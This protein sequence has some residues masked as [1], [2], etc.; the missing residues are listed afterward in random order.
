[1]NNS[2][3]VSNLIS[4]LKHSNLLLSYQV[5]SILAES[6]AGVEFYHAAFMDSYCS[7]VG[8]T[9]VSCLGHWEKGMRLPI[10]EMLVGSL[11]KLFNSLSDL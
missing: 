3:P 6:L 10:K 4:Q 9:F 8:L 7:A 1:M 5:H 2:Y 11:S